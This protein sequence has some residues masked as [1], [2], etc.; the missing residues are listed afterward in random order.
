MKIKRP[1]LPND[2]LEKNQDKNWQAIK[3]QITR[4]S[5]NSFSEKF[6]AYFLNPQISYIVVIVMALSYFSYTLFVNNN[7]D[8][9]TEIIAISNDVQTN[10]NENEDV[11][12]DDIY[13]ADSE[14]IFNNMHL[15]IDDDIDDF[16]AL[17]EI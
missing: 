17:A 15:D 1:L 11:A 4:N 3:T 14:E 5:E 16:V 6:S 12:E 9:N 8:T 10:E 13:I 7:I 2:L